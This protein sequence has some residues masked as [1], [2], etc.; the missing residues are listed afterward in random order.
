MIRKREE[1]QSADEKAFNAQAY[2][3]ATTFADEYVCYIPI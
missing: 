1:L 3:A 2:G